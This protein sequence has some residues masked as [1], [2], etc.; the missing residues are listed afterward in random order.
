M[1]ISFRNCPGVRVTGGKKM[2]LISRRNPDARRA[3]PF[4]RTRRCPAH[5][6][7]YSVP[8]VAA[9]GGLHGICFM[10]IGEA[11]VLRGPLQVVDDQEVAGPFGRLE[12]QPEFPNCGL[13]RGNK[14][15]ISRGHH[16]ITQ[17]GQR[18]RA[19]SEF[20]RG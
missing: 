17:C 12:A 20:F 11:L 4:P 7:Y 19:A 14:R 8:A 16:W 18:T 3:Q 1:T 2:R 9:F 10:P 15:R 6:D 13:Y 5:H